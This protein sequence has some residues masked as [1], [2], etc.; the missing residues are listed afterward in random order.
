MGGVYHRYGWSSVDFILGMMSFAGVS[1]SGV[2]LCIVIADSFHVFTSH[3]NLSDILENFVQL[4][5]IL[6]ISSMCILIGY[7]VFHAIYSLF[8][9]SCLGTSGDFRNHLC[10]NGSYEDLSEKI[11][12]SKRQSV[13]FRSVDADIHTHMIV[14]ISQYLVLG[15]L[16]HAITCLIL[17][18]Y[19]MKLY[20]PTW[21]HTTRIQ[22][23]NRLT[24]FNFVSSLTLAT[25]IIVYFWR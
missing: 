23:F 11:S 7:A 24:E 10:G 8:W 5:A 12:C 14:E 16:F 2:L 17:N 22:L 21:P 18:G 6:A 3:K 20:P 4:F 19:S 1:I 25:F 13:V 15:L 9:S